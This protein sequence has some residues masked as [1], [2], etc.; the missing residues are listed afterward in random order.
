[1]G[2]RRLAVAA[3]AGVCG[4]SFLL[5]SQLAQSASTPAGQI[6][7]PLAEYLAADN[8]V[9]GIARFGDPA[10]RA[11]VDAIG[12]T[13]LACDLGDGDFSDANEKSPPIHVATFATFDSCGPRSG[14]I[15]PMTACGLASPIGAERVCSTSCDR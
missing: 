10:T 1:M 14:R 12:V 4:A 8:E 11:Q 5:V 2:I 6:A 15:D 3:A 7:F 9:W 13:T